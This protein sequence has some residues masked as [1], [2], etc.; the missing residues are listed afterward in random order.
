MRALRFYIGDAVPGVP[1]GTPP[2]GSAAAAMDADFRQLRSSLLESKG[3]ECSPAFYV[4]KV[5]VL[6]FYSG[7]SS[8]SCSLASL[9]GG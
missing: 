2:A 5:R 1:P 3:F 6:F 7:R 8:P 4:Y 9:S